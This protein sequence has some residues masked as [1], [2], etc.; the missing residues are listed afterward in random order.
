[1]VEDFQIDGATLR[2]IIYNGLLDDK[3]GH[4]IFK[5]VTT[6][7]VD[8]LVTLAWFD[9]DDLRQRIKLHNATV[10][11]MAQALFFKEVKRA[12]ETR[13]TNPHAARVYFDFKE[14]L[15]KYYHEN[16]NPQQIGLNVL[17][18]HGFTEEEIERL[19]AEKLEK[20]LK[21][22]FGSLFQ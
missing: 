11:S 8:A 13:D 2:G 7:L 16:L 3:Y 6:A 15:E 4:E 21:K 22:A 19:T 17:A 10:D 5:I 9:F 12:V 14:N 18:I 20:E 1:M